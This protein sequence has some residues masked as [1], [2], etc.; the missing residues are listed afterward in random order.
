MATIKELKTQI[1]NANALG[2]A[3][4]TKQGID[5]SADATTHDIVSAIAEISGVNQYTSIVCNEDDTITLTDKDGVMHTMVCRYSE[6]G[7]LVSVT[8]DGKSVE[9]TYDGNKLVKV[10]GTVVDLKNEDEMESSNFNTVTF[11][12]HDG[13]FERI[14]VRKGNSVNIPIN[15]PPE[16]DDEVF[17]HW[18]VNGVAL[19]IPFTST[20]DTT[21][22]AVYDN[23]LDY[24]YSMNN[25]SREEHPYYFIMQGANN[26][27]KNNLIM[28]MGSEENVTIYQGP[29]RGYVVGKKEG[30]YRITYN[31]DEIGN[32]GA[33]N[34][35]ALMQELVDGN[36]SAGT[37]NYFLVEYEVTED[38]I[39]YTNTGQRTNEGT[40]YAYGSGKVE[41][42]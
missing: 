1:E 14:L 6:D 38:T 31:S 32:I 21:V 27:G 30:Y 12:S 23:V 5:I 2:V 24:V 35:N 20:S 40:W 16:R 41:E 36:A 25:I 18:A 37:K 10:G 11:N 29:E 15:A 34:P 7:K 4:L 26:L 42:I 9:L 33:G 28:L 22:E 3:N 17:T 19:P 8:Y 39:V 13:L